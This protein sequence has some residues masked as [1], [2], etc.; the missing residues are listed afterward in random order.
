M[1]NVSYC[2]V[3]DI[4]CGNVTNY[5]NHLQGKKHERKLDV[6]TFADAAVGT[7]VETAD[8]AVGE[9]DVRC[10]AILARR[11][12][13]PIGRPAPPSHQPRGFLAKVVPIPRQS[14][15]TPANR[16]QSPPKQPKVCGEKKGLIN[17]W[18]RLS[19]NYPTMELNYARMQYRTTQI[20]LREIYRDHWEKAV[21]EERDNRKRLGDWIKVMTGELP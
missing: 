20:Q 10:Y 19:Q 1:M 18:K 16:H 17:H 9:G 7:N 11:E 5:N 3:C 2:N 14:L 13:S 6:Q 4:E 15:I 21:W 12:R 8:A